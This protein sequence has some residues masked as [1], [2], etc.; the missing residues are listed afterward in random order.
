[1][2]NQEMDPEVRMT[3]GHLSILGAEIRVSDLD[4]QAEEPTW[5]MLRHLCHGQVWTAKDDRG[6]LV[7]IS[8]E[9]QSHLTTATCRH[10]QD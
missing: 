7:E 1:M 5:T 3:I 6:D 8:L 2:H 10:S 9:T 4:T